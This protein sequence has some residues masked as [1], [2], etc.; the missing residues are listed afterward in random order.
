MR[1]DLLDA[2]VDGITGRV[3]ACALDHDVRRLLWR[4]PREA[5]AE[6]GPFLVGVIVSTNFGTDLPNEEAELRGQAA[7]SAVTRCYIFAPVIRDTR[8][9]KGGTYAAWFKKPAGEGTGIVHLKDGAVTGGSDVF[10][11]CGSYETEGDRFSALIRT[12]RHTVGRHTVFGVDDLTLRLEGECSTMFSRCTGSVLEAGPVPL[13]AVP[14]SEK[15]PPKEDPPPPKPSR[16]DKARQ[17]AQQY[18]D[19][20]RAIAEKLRRE[21]N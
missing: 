10:T 12:K 15:E 4:P 1:A 7:F 13:Y 6:V 5:G 3:Q 18:L 21:L 17:V 11:Y 19:D 2:Y 9:L 8:M 20:Q 16:E 14:M